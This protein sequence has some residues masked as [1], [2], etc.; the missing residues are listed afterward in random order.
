VEEA[1][2]PNSDV[3]FT[4]VRRRKRPT[5]PQPPGPNK[6]SPSEVPKR[7]KK[8]SS[9]TPQVSQTASAKSV[10]TPKVAGNQPPGASKIPPVIVRDATKWAGISQAMAVKRFNFTKAKSCV[11]GIRVNPRTS[12]DHRTLTRLLEE[13]KIPFHSF[14]LPE[15][16]TLRA[17]LRTVPVEIGLDDVKADLEVQGL[18]PIKVTRMISGRSKLPLPLVLVEVPKD[19]GQ[20]FELRSVCHLRISVERPHKKGS[21]AQCHR[22]QRFHHSQK[23][24][25]ALAKCVKCGECHQSKD[26][27][28]PKES[29]AKCAN[30]GGPHTASYR[31]CPRFP[32]GYLGNKPQPGQNPNRAPAVS[33][34]SS[35]QQPPAAA[36]QSA[37]AP[38]AGN[39]PNTGKS[40]ADAAASKRPAPAPPTP[41]PTSAKKPAA[42]GNA[43]M[44]ILLAIQSSSTKD[45]ILGKVLAL[46]PNLLSGC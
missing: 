24:C 35:R 15:A 16:R 1:V 11:D 43:L 18:A 31:G 7:A 23:N 32:R 5:D 6:E 10:P 36:R 39:K 26:C 14:S 20:I 42:N 25:H 21:T 41:R 19:K 33:Q 28:K 22:C 29:P 30:Y 37:P 27:R 2:E 12:D 45:E 4:E 40:F 38:N 44:D 8:T 46:L 9:E 3:E 34:A 17:V 13:R